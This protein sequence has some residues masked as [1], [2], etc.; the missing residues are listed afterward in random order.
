M[1]AL[2]CA[3]QEQELGKA[4]GI[5]TK[6]SKVMA[7]RNQPP[8]DV[9]VG[10]NPVREALEARDARI[11]KVMLQKGASGAAIYAIRTVAREAGVPTQYVPA[12]RLDRMAPGLNH[13]GVVAIIA[14]IAYADPD[15]LLSQIAPTFDDVKASMPI[16]LV[17]DH[18]EDPF[19]FG[20]ML[21]SA[22]AAGVAGVFVPKRNMAPLNAAAL[23]TS[24]GTARTM[25]I[26]RIDSV[27]EFLQQ[28]KE[29]GYWVY[30]AAG[31]ES[32][33]SMWDVDWGRAVALVMGNEDKGL[34][35]TVRK[36]CDELIAI[37]MRGDVESL[38]ASVATGVLLFVATKDRT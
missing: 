24:A 28:L 18:I 26:A 9:L 13:Q 3:G 11:E 19:N 5:L 25:P 12:Q 8:S 35:P 29:R 16:V 21:R 6:K 31:D 33:T 38:N 36:A 15:E 30:G 1:N 17:L 20:G 34:Q 27:P 23:K 10:R 32:S 14:P 2:T 7:K 4:Q 37:P 22:V